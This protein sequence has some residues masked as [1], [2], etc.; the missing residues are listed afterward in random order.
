MKSMDVERA[1]LF[2]LW[3]ALILVFGLWPTLDIQF[4][5]LFFSAEHGFAGHQT[6]VRINDAI[7]WI[8]RIWLLLALAV[9]L[10][11]RIRRAAVSPRLRRS[12]GLLVLSLVLG[13][14]LLVHEVLKN[15]WGRARPLTVAAFGGSATFT[16]PL[17][18][19]KQCKRNCSFVSGHAATGFALISVGLLSPTRRRRHWLL[20]GVT[21]GLSIG[22]LRI[23][24]GG[25]FLSDILFCLAFMW[26]ANLLI[27]WAW[28]G[29]V[30]RRQ[31][32]AKALR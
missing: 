10:L 20:A 7:P 27:R 18:P 15:Q 14:G 4:S 28:I 5:A 12:A 24:L 23:A 22:L 6:L 25:H 32:R 31:Q 8:G 3:A 17:Q 9:L 26:G 21:L 2:G 29:L 1:A 13:L 16:S 30:W 19:A 11:G